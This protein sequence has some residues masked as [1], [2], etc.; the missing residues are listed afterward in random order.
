MKALVNF[1]VFGP[2]PD[3]IYYGG[4]LK[5]AELYQKWQPD[6]KLRFYLGDTPVDQ[7]LDVDLLKFPNTEVIHVPREPEDQTST[8]W[9]S[10]ALDTAPV[11][12]NFGPIGTGD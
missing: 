4:S 2:D 5:N 6:W 12:R 7:G 11:P 8:L 9:R 1:C 3:D 10:R